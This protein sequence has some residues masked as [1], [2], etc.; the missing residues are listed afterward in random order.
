[1]DI[2]TNLSNFISPR[3]WRVTVWF[4]KPV[5][6]GRPASYAQASLQEKTADLAGGLACDGLG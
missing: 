1:M 3:R 5:W 2:P 4:G 6:R